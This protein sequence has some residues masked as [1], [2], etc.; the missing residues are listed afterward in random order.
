MLQANVKRPGDLQIEQV[1]EPRPGPGEVLVSV[2]SCGICGT[3]RSIFTGGYPVAFPIV[4][5]HE[6]AGTVVAVG[7]RVEQLGVGDRVAVDPNVTCDTCAFCRRGLVHLCA[8]LSPLG[9][10]RPGGFAEFA[11]V[12]ERNAYRLPEQL[13]FE[14][15]ALIEPLACCVRGIQLAGI[16][17]GD[18]VAVLGAG[19]IGCMLLQLVRLEGAG[20]LIVSEPNPSR[21]ELALRLGADVAVDAG[22]AARAEVLEVTEG[23]GAD[24]VIEASGRARTAAFALEL[25]R[26]GGT[27]AWFGSCPESDRVEISPFWVNDNEIT[28]RGSFNNPFTHAQALR[29]AATGRVKL[30]E[31]VTDSVPLSKLEAA[32]DLANFPNAGKIAVIPG[33]RA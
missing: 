6:F 32:L 21:R 5:G 30:D 13:S 19:P 29:L 1:P 22:D 11:V 31:L 8:R 28:I 18:T 12:P 20:R 14:R 23:I 24:V 26:R 7:E 2:A 3:D 9:V 15:G 16:E 33:E 25:V 4:L 10:V 17:V 27:V